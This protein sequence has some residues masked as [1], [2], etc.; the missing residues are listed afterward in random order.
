MMKIQNPTPFGERV[1]VYGGGGVGKTEIV[2]DWIEATDL[3]FYIADIDVAPSYARALWGTEMAKQAT[4][5]EVDPDDLTELVRQV[6]AWRVDADRDSVLVIDSITPSWK[7][8]QDEW[9]DMTRGVDLAEL[10]VTSRKEMLKKDAKVMGMFGGDTDWTGIKALLGK[11]YKEIAKWPGHVIMTA[12]EKKIDDRDDKEIKAAYR[13]IGM[14][15]DGE[16]QI[17]KG[18]PCHTV[19]H[20]KFGR[21]DDGE[22]SYMM[23]TVKDRK[24]GGVSRRY[25]TDQPWDDFA[26]DYLRKVAGW[27]FVK[28]VKVVDSNAE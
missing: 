7:G 19:I 13:E 28:P 10:M 5:V 18:H 14:R 16:G 4:V 2:L 25:L 27:K 24:L 3:Q 23:T 17:K 12:Q 20:L 11:L 1:L 15:P 26:S 6:A 21:D 9:S 8:A 22:M